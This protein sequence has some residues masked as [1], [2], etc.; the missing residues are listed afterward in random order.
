MRRPRGLA[1]ALL[2]PAVVLVAP[3]P[4]FAVDYLTAEQAQ[5]EA[6]PDAQAF[7]ARELSLAPEQLQALAARL[8]EPLRRTRWTVRVARRGAEALGVVVVDEVIGKFEKITYAVALGR[9]GAIRGVEILSYRESHGQEVRLAAWRRQFVGK[10]AASPLRVGEDIA[11]I[12]GAT[13]SCTHV[14]QGV[15]RIAAVVEALR[16]A[17]A[18]P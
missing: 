11:G 13:L 1:Y 3:A 6:F 9:D 18:V 4:S 5:A 12:S 7:D 8:G 10:T 2:G 17:G 16:A 14:T 15:R